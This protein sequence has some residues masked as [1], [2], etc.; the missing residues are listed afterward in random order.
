MSTGSYFWVENSEG[1]KEEYRCFPLRGQTLCKVGHL[2]LSYMG[3][4]KEK[5]VDAGEW[6]T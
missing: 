2:L 5:G 4:R 3:P 6:A 1:E